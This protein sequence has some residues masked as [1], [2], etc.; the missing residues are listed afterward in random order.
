M[1]YIITATDFSKVA[2]NAVEYACGLAQAYNLPLTIV[3]S[4]TVPVAFHENPMPVIP[5][6]ES[7]KAAEEQMADLLNR[8]NEKYEGIAIKQHIF[9][10]DITDCLQELVT[11]HKPLAVVVGNSIKDDEG[12]WLGGNLMSVLKN[13]Q[14]PVIAIPE[15][16]K[17]TE[18]Q[19]IC[20]A[21]D[22]QNIKESLPAETITNLVEQIGASFHVLNVDHKNK[23]F[24]P[25]TPF[26]S[27]ELHNM[28]KN[29]K[30][31]YHYV[32]EEDTDKAIQAFV[33]AEKMDWLI[34]IPHKHNFFESLFHK[35]HTKQIVKNALVPIVA[36]HDKK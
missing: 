24:D 35:S 7:K 3:H 14:C 30:P 15:D 19:R 1:P 5:M 17:Y 27:T 10:G 22:Y 31:K 12:F 18:I 9:Y 4:Y 25:E 33:S 16:Y 13:V 23:S 8:L 29:I 36:L 26:E 34:V 20:F 6:E 28:L 11:E 21:C 32:E 2:D